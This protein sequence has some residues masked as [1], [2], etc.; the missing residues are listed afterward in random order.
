VVVPI[1]EY[2]VYPF[3]VVRLPTF[4]IFLHILSTFMLIIPDFGILV[5]NTE[6]GYVQIGIETHK[7]CI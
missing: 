7:I 5:P 1:L 6:K 3:T 2:F 4:T